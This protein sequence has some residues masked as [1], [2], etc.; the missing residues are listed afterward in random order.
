MKTTIKVLLFA[1]IA[2]LS[3]FCIM[4]ILTPIKFGEEKNKRE[5]EV[6]QSLIDLRAAEIEFKD[7]KGTY[8]IGVDTLVD[9][10]KTHKKKVV[11]KEGVLTDLQLE[12]GL[13]EG[14][15]A[16][17]VRKGNKKEIE[18]NGLVGFRRDTTYQN[19]I[20]AL[21]GDRFTPETIDKLQYIPYSDSVKFEIEINNNYLSANNVWV[22]L[23]E[24]RASYKAFLYEV[25][26]QETLNL[27]DL[28]KKM[29]K[30]PGLKVGSV[31]EPNNFAGNWE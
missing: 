20:V 9:F 14:K 21:Y 26:H 15:A 29:V 8:T 24:I 4:S 12:A 27:I 7:Q 18:A 30:F 16:S 2:V 11:L 10:L 31:I 19:L 1:A 3:Y 23:C 6:I 5:K 13:T 17:I 25:N 28:Q 22:P